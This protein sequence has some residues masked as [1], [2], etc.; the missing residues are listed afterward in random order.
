V[1]ALLKI[2]SNPLSETP[3]AEARLPPRN[4]ASYRFPARTQQHL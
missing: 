1:G 4:L 3:Y 2:V